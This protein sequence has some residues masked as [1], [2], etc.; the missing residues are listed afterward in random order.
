MSNSPESGLD[1]EDLE[2]Q[3]LPAWAKQSPD[4]NRYARFEGGAGETGPRRRDRQDSHGRQDRRSDRRSRSESGAGGRP[5]PE[6]DR[7]MTQTPK[8]LTDP[9]DRAQQT[10]PLDLLAEVLSMVRLTGAIFLRAEFTAPWAYESPPSSELARVLGP[11]AKRLILFHIIAEGRCWIRSSRGDYLEL[12]EGE[13]VV[14]PYADQHVVGSPEQVPSVPIGSLLPAPPWEQF[15]AIR[16][17]GG[18]ERRGRKS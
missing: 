3:F 16:Y 7:A 2:L 13:V 18:G 5:G 9:P 4:A 12:G 17:G 6:G 14:L 10:A 8:E 11:Q 1:L 15:P